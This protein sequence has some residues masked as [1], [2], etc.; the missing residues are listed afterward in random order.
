MTT[1]VDL[2]AERLDELEDRVDEAYE[3]AYGDTEPGVIVP[4]RDLHAII[5]MALTK[6]EAVAMLFDVRA[7]A[8]RAERERD[9]LRA[10]LAD[11]YSD[12]EAVRD[13]D[14]EC[15]W[16]FGGAPRDYEMNPASLPHADD[17][18]GERIRIALAQP[19]DA[20]GA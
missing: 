18:L 1:T 15:Y 14:E 4:A 20:G 19:T 3:R 7:R 11:A 8:V 10:L 6:H 16:C 9:A 13:P 17:C 2:T 5:A 12:R